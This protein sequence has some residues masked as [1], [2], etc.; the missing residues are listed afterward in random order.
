MNP[1]PV[2]ILDT[3]LGYLGFV[4][5]IE[6]EEQD[7]TLTL[8][9]FTHESDRLIGRHD[10]VLDDLQYLVN[11]ILAAQQPPGPRVIV[12]VEHYR[13]M[14]DDALVNKVQQLSRA[15]RATG[16]PIQ[17][18]P[19]NSY[20]RRLVHHAFKD[21]PEIT[22]WSPPDDARIKRITLRKRSAP[23]PQPPAEEK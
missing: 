19:L 6:Q 13:A 11:R 10:E 21:D 12:D 8:Q 2:E 1:T 22:T 18:E 4:V 17:T 16:R 5:T 23:K 7:G 9:I 15:V 20:D 14:R 3:L